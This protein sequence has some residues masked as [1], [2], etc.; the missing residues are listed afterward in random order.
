MVAETSIYLDTNAIIALVEGPETTGL[1][2]Q[3]FIRKTNGSRVA[4]NISSLCFAELLVIPY[5]N[6]NKG[7]AE[8]YLTLTTKISGL[9]I[10]AISGVI[11]DAAAVLRAEIS[12]LKLPDAIHL[13]TASTAKCQYFLTFDKDFADL[14]RLSHSLRDDSVLAPVKVIR[15]DPASL[16]ELFKALAP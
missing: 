2:L 13:A 5:R 3:D 1:A 6:K 12:R 11:L 7:L 8:E 10:H 9:S 15:P 16:S 4:F 14:P